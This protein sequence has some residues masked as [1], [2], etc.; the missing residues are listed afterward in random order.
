MAAVGRRNGKEMKKIAQWIKIAEE[1]SVMPSEIRRT[2]SRHSNSIQWLHKGVKFYDRGI[3]YWAPKDM[4]IRM[5]QDGDDFI[6][7]Q[8]TVVS[9]QFVIE[10]KALRIF[11]RIYPQRKMNHDRRKL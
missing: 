10:K 5:G 4:T 9:E 7:N 1:L 8:V 3:V 2:M 11:N 6:R